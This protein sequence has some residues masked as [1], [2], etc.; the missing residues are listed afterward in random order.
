M[1]KGSFLMR[2]FLF[3]GETI[4]FPWEILFFSWETILLTWEIYFF[5]GETINFSWETILF[6]WEIYFF[7]ELRVKKGEN[8]R[9]AK[10]LFATLRFGLL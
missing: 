2:N 7:S 5:P 10:M 1:R 3:S 4:N 6:T 8:K 9:P